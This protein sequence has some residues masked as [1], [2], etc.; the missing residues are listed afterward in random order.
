MSSEKDLNLKNPLLDTELLIFLLFALMY[1]VPPHAYTTLHL[2][3]YMHDTCIL[4]TK[5]TYVQYVGTTRDTLVR[6]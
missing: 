6:M 3:L 2:L 5:Y 1:N 4:L